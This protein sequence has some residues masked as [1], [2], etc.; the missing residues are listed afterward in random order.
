MALLTF[1]WPW[2]VLYEEKLI[3]CQWHKHHSR[4]TSLHRKTSFYID[5]I[6]KSAIILYFRH[7]EWTTLQKKCRLNYSIHLEKLFPPVFS[8]ND[9]R[10]HPIAETPDTNQA[11][12]R[13]KGPQAAHGGGEDGAGYTCLNLRSSLCSAPVHALVHEHF[14]NSRGTRRLTGPT[15]SAICCIGEL[16]AY[17]IWSNFYSNRRLLSSV[18]VMVL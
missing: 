9:Q 2:N 7:T 16:N 3:F 1:K 5:D 14:Y 11:E 18:L 13:H 17:L 6:L 12:S 8:R 10:P 15:G 4:I